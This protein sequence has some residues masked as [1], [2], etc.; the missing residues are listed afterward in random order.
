MPTE[1]LPNKSEAWLVR[2]KETVTPIPRCKQVV[3]GTLD[4]RKHSV[5]TDHVC[6]ETAEMPIE[7]SVQLE[8]QLTCEGDNRIHTASHK[9]L[10]PDF[11]VVE[12]QSDIWTTPTHLT[13][14][15]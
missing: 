5:R 3:R 10:T 14:C 15:C 9:T 12:P 8:L 4:G 2:S 7:G 13:L 1:I 11:K 6:V